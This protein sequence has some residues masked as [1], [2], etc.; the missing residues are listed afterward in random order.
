MLRQAPGCKAVINETEV[1]VVPA[2]GKTWH[3]VTH[4]GKLTVAA[5]TPPSSPGQLASAGEKQTVEQ[6]K[7]A[8]AERAAVTAPINE[9]P[10]LVARASKQPQP[11]IKPVGYEPAEDSVTVVQAAPQMTVV[12][13]DYR[14][15]PVAS[16]SSYPQTQ[17][18]P[19]QPR[20]MGGLLSRWF[21]SGGDSSTQQPQVQ[22]PVYAPQ[23]GP[24]GRVVSQ[25]MTPLPVTAQQ[26]TPAGNVQPTAEQA[27]VVNGV[28]VFEG[29]PVNPNPRTI[30]VSQYELK[31]RVETV[32]AGM[33]RDVQVVPGPEGTL[34]IRCTVT[35]DAAEKEVRDKVLQFP[36]MKSPNMRLE[37]VISRQ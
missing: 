19:A 15:V 17:P 23:S 24:T 30:A 29:D 21:G 36:E 18:Q 11:A 5:M 10:A 33:A 3:K 9:P 22:Q 25:P 8:N 16:G 7:P 28:V 34:V 13:N 1:A 12:G 35:G 2:H 6:E 20:R 32:A 14:L 26:I 31:R 27:R 4:D 37:I